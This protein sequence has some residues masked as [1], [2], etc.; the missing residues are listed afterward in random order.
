MDFVRSLFNCLPYATRLLITRLITVPC[1]LFVPAMKSCSVVLFAGLLSV[2]AAVSVAQ[3]RDAATA[4]LQFDN[5]QRAVVEGSK[6]EPIIQA[7]AKEVFYVPPE[8]V[9][10][11]NG[12]DQSG[13]VTAQ[14]VVT[15]LAE[16]PTTNGNTVLDNCNKNTRGGWFGLTDSPAEN[17]IEAST[18][19]WWPGDKVEV[20]KATCAQ[21]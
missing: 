10:L 8:Q 20:Q 4:T 17:A 16:G 14:S 12:I 7:L 19:T 13:F 2:F 18:D 15:F 3:E 21:A 6:A 5:S 1:Q 11:V 9:T